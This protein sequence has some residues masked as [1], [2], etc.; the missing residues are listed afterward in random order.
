[1]KIPK[2]SEWLKADAVA[3]SVG[4]DRE[5]KVIYGYVLAQEGPFKSEGRGEFDVKGLRQIVRL[6]KEKPNG[7]KSRFAHPSL[8]GDGIGTFLGRAKNIRMGNVQ[9]N[10]NGELLELNA[11]RGDLHLD[12][13]SFETPS[14]NLG[15]YVMTLAE[16]D[17]DAMS[18]SLV[19]KPELQYR[20]DNHGK[21]RLDENGNELPPLWWPV[22]LHASDIVDTGDAV[23]GFL[24]VEGLNDSLVRQ[25][26][27]LLKGFLPGQPRDVV[28]ARLQ[29]WLQEALNWRFGNEPEES[30][31]PLGLPAEDV[32]RALRH[33][34]RA[35]V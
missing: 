7:L 25:G 35:S 30:A 23:D 33:K 18:S 16:S 1:M 12:P 11:V 14:G 17:P 4:V 32:E 5:A 13:S 19:L 9:V 3:P 22:E 2:Q 15:E 6:A 31:E 24:S 34:M 21:P 20:L 10:R 28:E 26:C 8:S 27:E 29:S